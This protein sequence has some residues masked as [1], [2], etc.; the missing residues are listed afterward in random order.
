MTKF[1]HAYH[2]ARLFLSAEAFEQ[3]ERDRERRRLVSEL[4]QLDADRQYIGDR[5]GVILARM[6]LLNREDC[7]AV[8]KALRAAPASP[9]RPMTAEELAT[10]GAPLNRPDSLDFRLCVGVLLFG[11]VVLWWSY[12]W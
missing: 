9:E 3:R 1:L 8:L 10:H 4:E 11:A 6:N 7:G 12:T 2:V 5:S